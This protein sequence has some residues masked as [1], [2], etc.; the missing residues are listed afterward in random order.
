MSFPIPDFE[1]VC[2]CERERE[3]ERKRE[4]QCIIAYAGIWKQMNISVDKHKFTHIIL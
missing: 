4:K 1:R 2:L 3:R